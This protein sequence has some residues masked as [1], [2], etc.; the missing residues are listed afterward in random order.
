MVRAL[1]VAKLFL[2]WAKENGDLITNLKLQ[3][4]LYYAQ[5]WHLVNFDRRLFSDDIEA[6][7]FG[8]VIAD[9]YHH[10]KKHKSSAI[11]YEPNGKEANMF[12]DRQ[13]SFLTDFFRIFSN[14]SATALV[15]MSHSEDPW[16][17]SF[18]SRT[19]RKIIPPNIMKSFYTQLY[20]DL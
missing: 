11:P 7:D 14:L 3:K 1:G 6:W 20:A 19:T 17:K 10:W 5:A 18:A 8:P 9:V 13:I 12:S 4:L 16:K 2:A 15:S